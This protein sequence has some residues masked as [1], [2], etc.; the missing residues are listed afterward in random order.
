MDLF[1]HVPKDLTEASKL[2][3]V[4]SVCTVVALL[5][6]LFLE[7][8]S[9]LSSRTETSIRVTHDED[10]EFKVTVNIT[11]PTVSC[12][13]ITI[14]YL[15]V[16]GHKKENITAD[17]I[18]KYT[19]H[20]TYVASAVK[21]YDQQPIHYSDVPADRVVLH[22]SDHKRVVEMTPDNFDAVT[23]GSHVVLVDF[24]APWCPHC[25]RFAPIYEEAARQI[26]TLGVSPRDITLAAV[27]CTLKENQ[28]LCYEN[29][30]QAF[31]TVR[32]FREATDNPED[33]QRHM[34]EEYRGPRSAEAIAE[35]SMGAF[36][37]VKDAHPEI[38]NENKPPQADGRD[39]SSYGCVITGHLKVSRVPGTLIF[40][41]HAPNHNFFVEAINMSHVVQH[42]SF[43]AQGQVVPVK[44]SKRKVV[45]EDAGAY[46]GNEV[47][48][49][50][51]SLG[52]HITHE[53]YVKVVPRR[54][55]PLRGPI[56]EMY[57]YT[58]NSNVYETD[59]DNIP[60]VRL[61]WD[62]SP[63]EVVEKQVRRPLVEGICQL[64]GFLGGVYTFFMML[65]GTLHGA[66][67]RFRKNQEGKLG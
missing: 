54:F 58:I 16:V 38:A 5:T 40:S 51:L 18:H 42:L 55:E 13:W 60:S 23:K 57:E 6:L 19:L 15:D 47:K 41:P 2:G 28:M 11:F 7:V 31:P 36:K 12:D 8:N 3:G 61:V 63:M 64:V 67:A 52:N 39:Y 44:A 66:W 46:A 21:T 24:Y 29:H 37:E 50:F 33:G 22:D 43:G 17:T 56:I 49:L 62:I 25:V 59:K 1:R 30:I 14:D 48:T 34:H 65:E 53:H 4:I 35:F 27:D 32:V 20:G 26:E 45:E 10:E 9:L